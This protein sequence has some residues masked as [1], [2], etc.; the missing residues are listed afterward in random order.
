MIIEILIH[1]FFQ[2]FLDI[3]V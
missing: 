3:V 1:D 2:Y